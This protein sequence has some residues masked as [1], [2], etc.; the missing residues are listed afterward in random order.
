MSCDPSGRS[1]G[2]SPSST[3]STQGATLDSTWSQSAQC[4]FSPSCQVTVAV[5]PSDSILLTPAPVTMVAPA[6]RAATSR[7]AETAP[8]PP[9][10]TRHSPLPLPTT[11]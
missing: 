4:S 10:G 8:M 2:S 11:W 6:L 3:W 1:P 5:V 7:A 9:T